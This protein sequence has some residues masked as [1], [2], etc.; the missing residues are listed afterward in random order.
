MESLFPLPSRAVL[1]LAMLPGVLVV[2]PVHA[3]QSGV[4][5]QP[6]H[7]GQ[8]P[9]FSLSGRDRAHKDK[10]KSSD[11]IPS[12]D[13]FSL[14]EDPIEDFDLDPA[15]GL[16]IFDDGSDEM[17]DPIEDFDFGLD[18]P[19]GDLLSDPE[20]DLDLDPLLGDFSDPT[21]TTT[22]TAP[23]GPVAL[24][25]VGKQPLAG[26]YQPAIVAMDR[27]A[28]VVELPI[29]L[30]RSRADFGSQEFWIV[31]ELYAGGIKVAESRQL[32]NSSGMAEFGPTFMF[33]KLTAPVPARSGQLE[34]KVFKEVDG[35][36]Q[37]VFTRKLSYSLP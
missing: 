27:D 7:H 9:A 29:L 3:G 20:E 37:P 26:N 25:V 21:G 1:L 31:A 30:G 34:F 8:V 23:A 2:S 5:F 4:L 11:E 19:E 32:V 28:V 15:G 6:A 13:D 36:K 35:A 24:D 22:S 10:S 18:D 12:P 17:S 14:E 16:E 33:A